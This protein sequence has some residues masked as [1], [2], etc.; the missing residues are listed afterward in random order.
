MKKI[1]SLVL[2]IILGINIYASDNYTIAIVPLIQLSNDELN[3]DDNSIL[4]LTTSISEK[5]ISD[6]N[7][8][9]CNEILSIFNNQ[10]NNKLT[11]HTS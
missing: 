6:I 1:I 5:S 4:A 7:L 9:A 2:L 3:I 10:S 8:N 11:T